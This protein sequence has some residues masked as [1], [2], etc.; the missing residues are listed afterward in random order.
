MKRVIAVTLGLALLGAAAGGGYWYGQQHA[1]PAMTTAAADA[2]AAPAS[3]TAGPSQPGERKPLFY[4]NPMGL[5]DTSPV[6]KKDWMGMD[7]LPVYEGEEAVAGD[8]GIKISTAKIQR[9]GVRTEPAMKR[10]LMHPIQAAATIQFDE[11]R[12]TDVTTKYEGWIE[13]LMVNA[14]GEP[15]RQGQTLMMIYSPQMLQAQEEY[16]VALRL[17]DDGMS[18][19]DRLVHGALLRL[20]NLDLPKSVIDKLTRDQVVSRQIPLASPATGVV[21]EKSAV[22]GMRLMP[23]EKLYRLVD[24]RQMWVMADVFEQDLGMVQPGL[25]VSVRV[26]AYAGKIYK[27]K[28]AYIYPN[29]NRETRTARVRIEVPNSDGMLKADMYATVVLSAPTASDEVTV[30]ES[31]VLDTGDRQV[32]LVDMGE[33]RFEPRQVKLGGRGDGYVAVLDGVFEREAVVVS[34]NFLIDAESNLKAALNAFTA[35]APATE[36][37]K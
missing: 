28:V 26:N 25:D 30:P 29:L 33:G 6:P 3:G 22:E 12:L 8:G 13:K 19:A 23:G 1:K 5:P 18:D 4:R 35:G 36:T 15:V 2:A 20:R 27:G 17:K 37:P 31:A 34:A 21:M 14:T 16:L 9:L 7:Y 10:N 32:V 11:R 24:D